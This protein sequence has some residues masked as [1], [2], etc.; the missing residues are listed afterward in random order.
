MAFVHYTCRQCTCIYMCSLFRNVFR[1][2]YSDWPQES[3]NVM[4]AGR[5][6]SAV[7]VG[8]PT[9]TCILYKHTRVHVLMRDEKEGRKK[10]GRK[11]QARLN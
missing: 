1:N 5:E 8:L 2:T 4:T 3:V 11:K 6:N 7:K 9:C 10:E